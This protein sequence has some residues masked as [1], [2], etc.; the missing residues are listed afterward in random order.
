MITRQQL[1][2][3]YK[4]AVEHHPNPGAIMRRDGTL[5]AKS[6]AAFAAIDLSEVKANP[7]FQRRIVI[8]DIW[9]Q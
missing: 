1:D 8:N 9:L 6:H 7:L 5:K 3:A 2:E 4:N